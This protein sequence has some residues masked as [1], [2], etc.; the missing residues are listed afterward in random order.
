MTEVRRRN[1]EWKRCRSVNGEKNMTK[2]AG[3]VKM[4]L[5][6]EEEEMKKG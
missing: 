2:G 3:W 4:K 5:D 1:R 6:R